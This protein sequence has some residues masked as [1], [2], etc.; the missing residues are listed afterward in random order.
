MENAEYSQEKELLQEIK[1]G[2]LNWYDFRKGSSVLYIGREEDVYPC[3]LSEASLEV[4]CVSNEQTC[5]AQWQS[6][7]T[8]RF[9]YLIAVETLERNPAPGKTLKLWKGFLKSD[10]VL[11]LGV[12]NRFGLRYF[13]GDRDPYTSRNFD[14]IEGYRRAYAKLEDEFCGRCYSRAEIEDMLR[15]AGWKQV[16]FYSVFPGLKEPK[17]IYA[18]DYLPNE[19]LGN[20]LFPSYHYP[21]SV[22]LEEECLYDGLIKNHMFHQMANAYLVE[23]PL[24]GSFSNVLHV[25]SSME[26]GREYAFLTIVHKNGTVEKRAPYEEG[27]ERIHKLLEN[28]RNLAERGISVVDAEGKDCS[29][30]MPF[31]EAESGQ[32]YLKRL[33]HADREKFLTEMDH[34]RDLILKSSEIV[35]PD[36]G[37]GQGAILKKG[38]LDM[39]PLNSFHVNGTFMFYD[40]EFCVENYP[41]NEIIWRMIATFYAG[42]MEL[43]KLFPMNRLLERYGLM[44]RLECWQKMEWDFLAELRKEKELRSYHQTHPLQSPSPPPMQESLRF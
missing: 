10:G 28:G 31:V 2:L 23:C 7:H 9:D 29:C 3:M 33:F 30:I 40:Q 17:L 42:D 24:R 5:D 32:L 37:G 25:T 11:L 12:N 6:A 19:D 35:E 34:F 21:N 4:T 22:F 38:Y 13:C 20:R 18:E 43:G 39:V 16:R 44:E 15:A 8:S 1:K 36:R 41:A 26:R 27:K 14:G